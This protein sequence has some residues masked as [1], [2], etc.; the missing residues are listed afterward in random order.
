M[1]TFKSR[2]FHGN[3]LTEWALTA[4]LSASSTCVVTDGFG[5]SEI[6]D[7][8]WRAEICQPELVMLASPIDQCGT[9]F[10][11]QEVY[12]Q[13]L[14]FCMNPESSSMSEYPKFATYFIHFWC[15]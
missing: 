12:V 9:G 2:N 10:S 7:A 4:P 1:S 14:V 8:E 5:S 15:M 6:L 11:L 13:V 3:K